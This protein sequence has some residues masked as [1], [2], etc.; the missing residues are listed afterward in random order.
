MT[1]AAT[2]HIDGHKV[3]ATEGANLLQVARDNGFGIPGLC[4]HPRVS[5]SGACRLC[6][7]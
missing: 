3:E 6:V 4:Y 1:T 5:V 2:I 7:V